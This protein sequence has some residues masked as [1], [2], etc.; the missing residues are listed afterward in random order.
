VTDRQEAEIDEWFDHEV[1]KQFFEKIRILAENRKED[2]SSQ[3]YE[4]DSNE[5][6]SS[7]RANWWGLYNAL[8]QV[9]SVCESKTFEEIEE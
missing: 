7:E 2:L 8:A 9:Y 5:K 3:G 4:S 1:T 6:L